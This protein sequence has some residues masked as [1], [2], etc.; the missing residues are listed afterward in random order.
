M[1]TLMLVS[2]LLGTTRNILFKRCGK[3]LDLPDLFLF[4]SIMSVSAVA[5]LFIASKFNMEWTIS[6]FS[7][8]MAALYA[9]AT[10]IAQVSYI[11]AV[12]L[13]SVALSTLFYSC[14]FTIP[15]ILGTVIWKE[16]VTVLQI[17]GFLLL[18]VSF[19]VS[20]NPGEL[21]ELR[22]RW[23]IYAILSFI[24]SGFLG[25][26]QKVHQNSSYKD[27]INEF[28][29]LAFIILSLVS[30]CSYKVLSKS[31]TERKLLRGKFA[32]NAI[33][34]GASFGFINKINTYLAGRLPGMIF[35]PGV[36][37]GVII[38]STVFAYILLKERLSKKQDYGLAVGIL[39]ILLICI[40][41]GD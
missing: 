1:Y 9:A 6:V 13:G 17:L 37:G 20:T 15:T 39:A 14:G 18:L 7:I 33:I 38:S 8:C 41:P 26:I 24:N 11:K 30:F 22:M 3:A 31:V 40:F 19:F 12:S 36:N 16:T 25:L 34:I 28:L 29:L 23:L 2:I 4:Y 5:A 10:F 32:I 21:Y 35:F 27:E